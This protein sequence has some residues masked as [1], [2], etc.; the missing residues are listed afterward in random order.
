MFHEADIL[1]TVEINQH[2]QIV[3]IYHFKSDTRL[4]LVKKHDVAR[5]CI[6]RERLYLFNFM[7]SPDNKIL[8]VIWLGLNN[9]E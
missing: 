6:E 1:L 8:V 5:R 3:V 9:Q 7:R 2:R 4:H